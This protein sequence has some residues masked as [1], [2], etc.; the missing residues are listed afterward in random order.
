MFLRQSWPLL[1]SSHLL[2]SLL[3]PEEMKSDL[4]LSADLSLSDVARDKWLSECLFIRPP[5]PF[6]F[7][8]LLWLYCSCSVIINVIKHWEVVGGREGNQEDFR[9]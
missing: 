5:L 3:L 4:H 8:S 1:L 7:R 9:D 2:P 6:S